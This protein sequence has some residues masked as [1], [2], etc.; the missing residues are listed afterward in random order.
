MYDGNWVAYMDPKNKDKRTIDYG[1][2]NM[3]GTTDW[4]VD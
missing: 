4:A 3:A 2:L 1:A